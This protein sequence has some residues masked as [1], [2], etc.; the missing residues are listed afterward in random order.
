MHAF[1]SHIGR[2]DAFLF[3]RFYGRMD[4]DK[5]RTIHMKSQ[6]LFKHRRKI[7]M[8]EWIIRNRGMNTRL[9]AV[10]QGIIR[11][12]HTLKDEFFEAQSACV[13]CRENIP[14]KMVELSDAWQFSAGDISVRMDKKSGA[15]A[16]LDADGEVLLREPERR[17]RVL[18]E[19]PVYR[20]IMLMNVTKFLLYTYNRFFVVAYSL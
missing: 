10:S 9:Q 1:L 5:N 18:E 4:K 17:P 16:F 19:V 11:V 20:N 13:V 14:A 8:H 3:F 2:V 15:M 6:A 12:T 7:C